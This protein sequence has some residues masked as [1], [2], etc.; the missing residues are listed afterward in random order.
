MPLLILVMMIPR[1]MG[2]YGLYMAHNIYDGFWY[3]FDR[4]DAPDYWKGTIKKWARG[5]SADEALNN[6]KEKYAAV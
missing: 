6:Y 4:V 1:K 3:C 5:N 2:D